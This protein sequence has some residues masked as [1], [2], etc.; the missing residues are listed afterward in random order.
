MLRRGI[1]LDPSSINQARAIGQGNA[2]AG[3]RQSLAYVDQWLTVSDTYDSDNQCRMLMA[4]LDE[5]SIR[6]AIRIGRG[7]LSVGVRVALMLSL[8]FA[9]ERSSVAH[10]N[11]TA[12]PAHLLGQWPRVR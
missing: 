10:S 3:I 5:Q 6:S 2:S 7:S 1:Y 11:A 12:H 8:Q 9:P 4:T